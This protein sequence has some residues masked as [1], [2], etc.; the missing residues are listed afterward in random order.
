MAET[1]KQQKTKTT[2]GKKYLKTSRYL[3][4]IFLFVA[5]CNPIYIYTVQVDFLGLFGPFPDRALLENPDQDLSSEL[6]SVDNQL[7]GKYFTSNRTLVDYDQLSPNLINALE[8]TEDIRFEQHSGID[9][10]SLVRV[11]ANLGQAGGGSTITQQLAKLLFG[12]RRTEYKGLLSDVPGLGIVITKTKEMIL[13]VQLEKSYTKQEIMA[14]YLNTIEYGYNSH[15]IQAASRAFF[16]TTPDSLNIQDA[17]MI[18][19]ILNRPSFYNPL[20]HPD[21]A[22]KKRTEVL[23]NIH[24]YGLMDRATYDSIN[25]LPLGLQFQVVNQNQ[26]LAPYFRK[27]AGN[28]LRQWAI[29]N[30]YDLYR[31]GL[32]IY[33]T[34]DTRMQVYAEESVKEHMTSLQQNFDEHWKGRNPWIDEKWREIRNFVEIRK[35]NT[36]QYKSFVAQYGEDS[37]SVEIMMNTPT[38]LS[39]FSWKGEIDTLMS[40]IDSLKYYKRFLQTGF[41]AMDPHSGE[42]KAWV[43]GNNHKYFKYD[44]VKQGKRQ[45]GSTFKPFVYTAAIEHGYTPCYEAR[46]VKVSFEVVGDPPTWSP[47]NAN[48]KYTGDLMTLRQGLARSVNSI[49]AFLMKQV[50]PETVVKYAHNMGIESDLDAVPALCLG[51]SDVSLFELVGA[52]STFVNRGFHNDPIFVKRIEDKNGNVIQEFTTT[53]NE[54]IKDETA[55]VMLHMLRGGTEEQGGTSM[56]LSRDLRIDNQV[57]AKTGTTNNASDGWYMGLTKDLVAGAW[58]GGDERSIHY[59][60]W[61]LGS[62]GRTALPI[63]DKFMTKIYADTTLGYEKGPFPKPASRLSIELNCDEHKRAYENVIIQNGDTIVIDEEDKSIKED[64][65]F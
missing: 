16:N 12:T 33:T 27:V 56:G 51:V 62:G 50:T 14:M 36:P 8:V 25:K 29:D 53:T 39:V 45:P 23:W 65:I 60:Q 47:E 2:N 43:G 46:D 11:V 28:W 4:L 61:A 48:G 63:W 3:W 31:D 7:L 59:R 9:L 52:Y 30:G 44:H 20:R 15:G 41:M 6:Y 64:E 10:R 37:D 13:A 49:T 35:K 38:P 58:V 22:L 26:G 24:K 1:K 40:P 5:A 21:R 42:V 34:I 55:Y 57:A 32:K 54:A 18:V 19:G 17:A